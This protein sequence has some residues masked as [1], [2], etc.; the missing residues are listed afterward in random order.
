MKKK[1]APPHPRRASVHEARVIV[2][3]EAPI[4]ADVMREHHRLEEQAAEVRARIERFES[5]D[6]PAYTRWEARVLGPLLTAIRDAEADLSKKRAIL[7]AIEDEVFF[8]G[9]SRLA[10][11]KRVM[12]QLEDPQPDDYDDFFADEP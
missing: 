4:R 3:D 9:C 7:E 2:V 8:S 12:R 11:Y 5:A 1:K 10:A 6:L